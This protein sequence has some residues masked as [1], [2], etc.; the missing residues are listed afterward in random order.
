MSVIS[1]STSGNYWS[2]HG[3]GAI[4]W[5]APELLDPQTF[6]L[7]TARPTF[8]SDMY[9]F[10]MT[11]IEVEFSISFCTCESVLTS[12]ILQLY[13]GQKPFHE[14]VFHDLHVISPVM[15]GE[16]PARPEIMS[17]GV[18]LVTQRCWSQELS[19]R[20]KAVIV[21]EAMDIVHRGLPGNAVVVILRSHHVI[22]AKYDRRSVLFFFYP[23]TS[24]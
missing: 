11:A 21:A 2:I 20:P 6:G 14:S 24:L 5:I 7:S 17:D 10:A 22:P 19:R 1:E 9:S 18:W 4:R 16:R 8:S 3:G 15:K 13:T 12:F 23:I